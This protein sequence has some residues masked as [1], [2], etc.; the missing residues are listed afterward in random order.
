VP[1]ILRRRDVRYIVLYKDMP[2]RP[3]RDYWRAF[4]RLP[5]RYEVRFENGDVLI[6]EPRV[7]RP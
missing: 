1:G 2:D 6:V 7:A 3:T 4:L 5:E